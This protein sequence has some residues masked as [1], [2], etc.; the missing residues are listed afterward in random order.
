MRGIWHNDQPSFIKML[1]L[2]SAKGSPFVGA[3]SVTTNSQVQRKISG[4]GSASKGR[5]FGTWK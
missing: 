3:D 1:P 4:A 2:F 5:H